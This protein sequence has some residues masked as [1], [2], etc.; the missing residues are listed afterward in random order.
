LQDV[1]WLSGGLV[2][3]KFI[4]AQQLAYNQGFSPA[5]GLIKPTPTG[6]TLPDSVR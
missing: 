1:R 4:A 5:P 6:A 3:K 2:A